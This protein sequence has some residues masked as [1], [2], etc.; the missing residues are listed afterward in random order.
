[1]VN[2]GDGGLVADVTDILLDAT[3]GI[4]LKS[5]RPTLSPLPPDV[6]ERLV[7]RY[8]QFDTQLTLDMADGGLVGLDSD[9]TAIGPVRMIDETHFAI[10]RAD[11]PPRRFAVTWAAN[12]SVR[13]L[14]TGFRAL[15]RMLR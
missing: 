8:G 12:G 1:M 5:P 11:G 10:E 15:V 3:A 14:H 13:Y 9:G 7:G 4:T 2:A 6:A